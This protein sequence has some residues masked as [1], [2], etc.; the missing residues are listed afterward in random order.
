M[1]A[2]PE[3]V[4]VRSGFTVFIPVYNEADILEANL[5]RLAAFLAG[6]GRPFEVIVGSNGS[7]DATEDIGRRLAGE[8]A[9]LE[10]FHLPVKGPGLAFREG[11]RRARYQLIVTQDMDLSV[12]LGFIPQALELMEAADLIIGSKRMGRQER[13]WYRILGS[14]AYILAARL[15]LGLDY[16]DYSLAA[17]AYRK[18]LAERF[19]DWIDPGTAYVLNLTYWARR[20]G[21]RIIETPVFCQDERASRFNLIEE[22][23]TRF[24]RLG[25]LWLAAR[26]GRPP[27]WRAGK[28]VFFFFE[29][30]PSSKRP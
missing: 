2:I 23:L 18:E 9:W 4:A 20:C 11:V 17:K 5:R 7:T 22:G 27:R 14:G 3:G 25:R 24:G 12:D 21:F 15:L 8:T 29:R 1:V 28:R 16:K 26:T 19:I 10:F 30:R 13:A 6:L